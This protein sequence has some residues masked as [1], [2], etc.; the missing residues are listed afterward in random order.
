[1]CH[2]LPVFYKS[3]WNKERGQA[4]VLLYKSGCPFSFQEIRNKKVE[5][6]EAVSQL[7]P[8]SLYESSVLNLQKRKGRNIIVYNS[9]S[10]FS[11]CMTLKICHF[12]VCV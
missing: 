6:E 8:Q 9:A 2:S 7:E 4:V 3:K 1:V 10:P 11:S 12:S 5:E